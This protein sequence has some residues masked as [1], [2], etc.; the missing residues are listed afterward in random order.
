M[1]SQKQS[2]A[3][4]PL[5]AV[6]RPFHSL[7]C[8]GLAFVLAV[9]ALHAQDETGP[10]EPQ[11]QLEARVTEAYGFLEDGN[12]QQALDAFNQVLEQDTGFLPARLGQAMIYAER[13]RHVEAF[14][15]FD[16]IVQSHPRHTFAWNGRGL[17]AFNLQNFNEA[18]SSFEQAT[19][20]EPVNGFYYESLAWTHL[21]LGDY[22]EARKSAKTA[23]LMYH[24]KGESS[25][26][27]LL[28]AYFSSLESGATADARRTLGYA[29]SNK[30]AHNSWPHPVFD[31]LA[32]Q[33][34]A[35]ELISFVKDSAQETEAHTYIGLKLR[36]AGD[37]TH[38]AAHLRW[39]AEHGDQ[40]VF[41]FRLARAL[42]AGTK[43]AAV[44]R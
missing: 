29:L 7:R 4:Q 41:E 11:T 13:Q 33:V 22:T 31:Y 3:T 12:Q 43:V 36:A 23:T 20:D 19:R 38:A 9:A 35:P 39:V 40:R 32:G 34:D 44:A 1:L 8:C 30:P 6:F 42:N 37:A 14:N 17:A 28:I 10:A 18:L 21:C 25:A 16:L 24:Q 5:A 26:Y 15:A 2:F 27:P